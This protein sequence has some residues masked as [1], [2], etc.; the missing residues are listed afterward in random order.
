VS[1]I[2]ESPMGSVPSGFSVG[3]PLSPVHAI[4]MP[5][6]PGGE[7]LMFHGQSEERVWPIATD[8]STRVHRLG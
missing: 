4:H 5:T 2:C 1:S 3:H 6:P 8:A 7:L